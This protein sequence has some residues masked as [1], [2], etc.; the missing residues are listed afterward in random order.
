MT[1]SETGHDFSVLDHRESD[2]RIETQCARTCEH[3]LE[4]RVDS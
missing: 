2:K 1:E 3:L 4:S